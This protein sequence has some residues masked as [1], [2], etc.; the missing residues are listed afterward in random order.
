P[1]RAG[2][3]EVAAPQEVGTPS[4]R[5][6]GERAAQSPVV[7]EGDAAVSVDRRRGIVALDQ[8]GRLA[9][10]RRMNREQLRRGLLVVIEEDQQL[11]AGQAGGRVAR[12]PAAGGR[13]LS[14]TQPEWQPRRQL[15]KRLGGAVRGAV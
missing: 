6:A 13:D 11:S 2:D 15:R 3:G 14:P 9:L 5:H 10:A 1:Y 7:E 12:R 4:R 8:C